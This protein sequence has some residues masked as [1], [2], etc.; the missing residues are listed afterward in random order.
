MGNS[1]SRSP[2]ALAQ[3][4]RCERQFYYQRV[5]RLPEGPP[6]AALSIGTL[7]H[8]AIEQLV[9]TG[10]VSVDALI[11]SARESSGWADPG[12]TDEALAAELV[13]ALLKVDEVLKQYPVLI[14]DD[15]PMVE[16]RG[17][18][19]SCRIDY[20]GE[21]PEGR[22]VLDWKTTASKRRRSQADADN[23]AQLALYCIETGAH[24]AAFVEIPRDG[25]P[26]NLVASSF[27]DWELARWAA[28]LDAQF[29]AM[30]SR[31]PAEADFRLA[32]RGH[33]LCNVRFCPYWSRC[34]GGGGGNT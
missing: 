12:C 25:G 8:A 28:Y 30:N 9:R 33:P 13:V 22:T 14:D 1:V 29:A 32:A 16:R 4:E 26:L 21:G 15:G 5:L 3:F 7:Y 11:A 17:K 2:T 20:V 18:K 34:P 24:H 23:S 6:S 27:D 31:G 19:Y 10:E